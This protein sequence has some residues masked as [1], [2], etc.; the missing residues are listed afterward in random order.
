MGSSE[1]SC[2]VSA[3]TNTKI[4]ADGVWAIKQLSP[5]FNDKQTP[6]MKHFS[7]LCGIVVAQLCDAS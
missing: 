4:T 5:R 3:P 7:H 1:K 2:F 6:C